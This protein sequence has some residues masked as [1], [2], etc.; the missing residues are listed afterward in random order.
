M[1]DQSF[2][3][4][5]VDKYGPNGQNSALDPDTGFNVISDMFDVAGSSF[6]GTHL[7]ASLDTEPIPGS[8]VRATGN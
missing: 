2:F 8:A 4:F 3:N 5:L 1:N 6:S 7:R